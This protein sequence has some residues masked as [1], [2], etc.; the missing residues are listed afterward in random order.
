MPAPIALVPLPQSVEWLTGDPFVPGEQLTLAMGPSPAEAA[1]GD[2]AAARLGEAAGRPV[3][4]SQADTGDVVF[5]LAP[6]GAAGSYTLT[7]GADGVLVEGA[8]LPG[9]VHGLATLRQLLR[10]GVDTAPVPAVRIADAPRFGWRGLSL[11]IARHYFGPEQL[12]RVIELLADYK[13]NVLHLHLSDDQGWRIDLPSRPELVDRS[14]KS[15]VDGDPG[16]YLTGPEYRELVDFAAARGITIVPEIDVPGHVN[17]ALHAVPELTP[18]GEAPEVYTGIEVGFSKLTAD[19]PATEPF[20]REVFRDLAELTPGDYLHI[21]GDEVLTMEKPE[22]ARLV[23]MAARAVR[24]AGKQV[25]GWQEIATVPLEPGTVVQYWEPKEDLS[26]F[27][28]AARSG[29][30]FIMS[31]G[32]KAYLDMKYH[33]GFP[34]GLQ[35][36]GFVP[37]RTSYEWEPTELIDGVP[38]ESVLGVEAAVWTE[39]LRTLDELT[40]MLLPRLTAVAEVAWTEPDRRDWDDYAE[41]VAAQAADWRSRGLVFHPAEPVEWPES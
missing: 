19:L 16:G 39:T 40:T 18:S 5:R 8:D 24:D 7:A 41:R 36:A 33:E 21:G 25:I 32:S 35:W 34:L 37:L 17:A 10:P 30:R 20:L 14:G 9:L 11:D 29:A 28:E 13:F 15:A 12:Q 6:G 3:T 4:A 22:Y 38:A 2:L 27:A 1:L 26:F 23:D 31:P